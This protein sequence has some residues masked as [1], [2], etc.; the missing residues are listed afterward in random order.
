MASLQERILE[1]QCYVLKE[2]VEVVLQ[3]STTPL[4]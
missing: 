1:V 3:R 2:F 4:L